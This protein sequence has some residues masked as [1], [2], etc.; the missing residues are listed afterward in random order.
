[1]WSDPKVRTRQLTGSTDTGSNAKL[2]LLCLLNAFPVD[3]SGMERSCNYDLSIDD[4]PVEN[5]VRT[6]LVIG[7]DEGVSP[8]FEEFPDTKFILDCA[9]QTGLFLGPFTSFVE[10]RKN[11]DL[12]VKSVAFKVCKCCV[13]N[14]IVV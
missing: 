2:Q 5:R 9:E 13:G 8:L 1:M 7:D 14:T 3:V 12:Q 6:L 4:F 11:F 10:N